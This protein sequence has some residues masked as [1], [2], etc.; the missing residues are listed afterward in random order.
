MAES[1]IEL[2]AETFDREAFASTY[3]EELA[4][5]P[6]VAE[7]LA[8]LDERAEKMGDSFAQDPVYQRLLIYLQHYVRGWSRDHDHKAWRAANPNA[9]EAADHA[10]SAARAVRAS[11]KKAKAK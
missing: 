2:F 8:K 9:A 1:A 3:A 6:H 5:H 4:A 10:N 11:A 7:A